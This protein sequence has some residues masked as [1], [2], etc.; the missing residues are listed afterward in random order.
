MLLLLRG[1]GRGRRGRGCEGGKVD[2]G[3]AW[4]GGHF[5]LF[6]WGRM[7]IIFFK[8]KKSD[9]IDERVFVVRGEGAYFH[10]GENEGSLD[11]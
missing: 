3:D 11:I 2:D 10:S 4:G 8:R 9:N 7:Y 6:Y 5:L 1:R